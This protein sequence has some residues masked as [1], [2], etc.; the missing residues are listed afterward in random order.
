MSV[1]K[2][3]YKF[4]ILKFRPSL[5][6]ESEDI[7][8]AVIVESENVIALV[9]HEP[10]LPENFSP[11]ARQI[12]QE[13]PDIL[14]KEIEVALES[15]EFEGAINLL[16]STLEWNLLLSP[17]DVEESSLEPFEF[18]FMQFAR[19]ILPK[20]TI[21]RRQTAT[22]EFRMNRDIYDLFVPKARDS[23]QSA[24]EFA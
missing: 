1:T 17:V 18:A 22:T 21:I 3:A 15:G 2:N 14:V 7:P 16:S 6:G 19:Q 11:I 9:G 5:I 8:L 10:D 24:L 4:S 20:D 12:I 13:L 23:R